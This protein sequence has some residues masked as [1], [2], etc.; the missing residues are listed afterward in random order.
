MVTRTKKKDADIITEAMKR[1]KAADDADRPE[2]ELALEDLRFIFDE[3]GQWTAEDKKKREGRPSFTFDRVSGALDQ[4]IGDQL[5]ARPGIKVRA[6]EDGD[7]DTAEIYT[8]LIRNIEA[9]TN[10]KSA[11]SNGFKFSAA[12]GYGCWLVTHDYKDE[13]TFDQDVEIR[14]IANPFSALFDPN[15]QAV[16]KHDG[17]FQFLFS[18]MDKDDFEAE[19]PK[20]ESTANDLE[21]AGNNKEWFAKDT[22]RIADYWRKVPV[23]VTLLLLSDGRTLNRDDAEDILDE[24]AA[25]GIEVANERVVDSYKI[26]HFKI[27]GAEVLEEVEFAG[28]YFPIIPIYGKNINLEGKFKYRG[29]VRKA[30]DAQR[31]Y[32]YEINGF[33]ETVEHQPKMPYFATQAMIEGH[34]E[35]WQN[36][37]TS[38]DPVL[39]FNFDNG[40]KPFREAPPQVSQAHMASMSVFADNIKAQTGIYDASLGGRSNETSGK[41]IRERDRQGDTATYEYTDGLIEALEHTGR[42]L[43]DLIPRIIDT[44]RQIRILGQD[45][46]E[47]VIEVNKPVQ[48][49]QTGEWITVNDLTRGKYDLVVT[50]GSSY[51]TKR[52]ETAEQ[53]GQIM[54]QNPQMGQ[55]FADVYIKSLDLVGGDDVV[56]RI[57]KMMI[58]QGVVE[59]TDEE[60]QEMQQEASSPEARQK[61]QAQDQMKQ[62]AMQME[63][64]IKQAKVGLDQANARNKDSD[65][66]LNQI[67]AK[68]AQL[69][70][71]MAQQDQQASSQALMAMRQLMSGR[72]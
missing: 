38:N 46:A 55:L 28:K 51:A 14:P 47:D 70:L 40:Q 27:T 52:T 71:A 35:K 49:M 29:I 25:Q 18:D 16:T 65:T 20:A 66:L 3:D 13:D 4:L 37:N 56:K 72:R 64:A 22:V 12:G 2:R 1:F 5:Q 23:K 8:G 67:E 42:V 11:Y 9:T 44:K 41:A 33:I 57:R 43:I 62:K 32:N 30:K 58:K 15:C 24:L 6:S 50:S 19:Y 59:P 60:K 26:E 61:K 36:L 45:D 39:L 48:D 17:K 54:A 53:L 7:A 68:A 69:E 63:M 21:S 34:E 10:A 31:L